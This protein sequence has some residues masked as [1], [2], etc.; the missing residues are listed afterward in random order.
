MKLLQISQ[1][2]SPASNVRWLPCGMARAEERS[3]NLSGFRGFRFAGQELTDPLR[4]KDPAK[5]REKLT[6]IDGGGD[7]A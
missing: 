5:A 3:L 2:S 6:V 4:R 1:Q 7:V